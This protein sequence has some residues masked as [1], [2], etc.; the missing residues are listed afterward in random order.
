MLYFEPRHE[1]KLFFGLSFGVSKQVP[2]KSDCVTI[3]DGLSLQILD[4]DRKG[5]ILCSENKKADQLRSYCAADL[6]LCFRICKKTGFLMTW[7]I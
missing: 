4:F 5:T 1:K 6:R 7:L 3:E 2:H